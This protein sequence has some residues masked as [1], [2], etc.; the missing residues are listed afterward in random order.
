MSDC[1]ST[2]CIAKAPRKRRCPE[3]G[4]ECP[5]VS[6]RTILH[7]V[8]RPWAWEEKTQGYYFCADPGCDVVYFGDDGA[9]I[10]R[11]QV[12]T[13]VGVKETSKQAPLCYCFGVSKE[14]GASDPS[15]RDFV[16]E[17]TRSGLCSCETSNPSGR[18]CLA[19]F[20]VNLD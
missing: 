17:K 20:P 10:T 7:H 14:E 12:R 6:T 5:E 2:S 18:C 8:K 9:V 1:C 4:F 16:I 15:L 11:S 3:S 19:D 13:S